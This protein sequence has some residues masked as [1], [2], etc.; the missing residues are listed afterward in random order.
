MPFNDEALARAI[1][2]MPVAVVTG[3]G[4]EPDT[5]IADMVAD[6]RASTP[7]AAA[8]AVAPAQESLRA[9]LRALGEGLAAREHRQVLARRM[10]V[11]AMRSLP[12]F[13][14]PERLLGAYAQRLDEAADRLSS[15][16]PRA[17]ERDRHALEGMRSLM[18]HALAGMLRQPE[19][20]VSSLGQRLRYAGES[21]L[22]RYGA[23]VSV[24]AARL[25]DLSPLAV[26]ARGY[27]VARDEQ[28]RIV[29]S[30]GAV[31]RGS[32][33]ALSV[34]DGVV[35]C[36]VLDARRIDTAVETL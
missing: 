18:T 32:K 1:A 4:H 20:R 8:E 5:S 2:E 25:H 24:A 6:V 15:A 9:H 21:G 11:D 22:S 29:K 7:T 3:I 19:Q 34:A 36:E 12:L 27:A 30:V 13:R 35:D 26:I 10:R 28:G 14:E 23:E 17:L 16:L 33:L 31:S